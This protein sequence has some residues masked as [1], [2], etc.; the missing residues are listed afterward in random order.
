MLQT[1]ENLNCILCIG[2]FQNSILNKIWF[3]KK[4][5]SKLCFLALPN[6]ISII[7][8]PN[9][10]A[11]NEI[12]VVFHFELFINRFISSTIPL[13]EPY[14]LVILCMLANISPEFCCFGK[15]KDHLCML[16]EDYPCL[17]SQ[18]TWKPEPNLS[19]YRMSNIHDSEK[20]NR[21]KSE[22]TEKSSLGFPMEAVPVDVFLREISRILS[23]FSSSMFS[24]AE[25][26]I[27]VIST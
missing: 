26:S 27:S 8:H 1:K 3:T 22:L 5:V 24:P 19:R 12:Q 17:F 11:N 9:A 14:N 20:C 15:A 13:I 23:S 16:V 21:T 25:S 6:D 10:S 2:C 7:Y 4:T 18:I